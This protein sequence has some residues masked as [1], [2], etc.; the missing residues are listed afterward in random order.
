MIQIWLNEDRYPQK[1]FVRFSSTIYK[2]IE[3]IYTYNQNN[4]ESLR[5]CYKYLEGIQN[6]LSNP[7]I[8]FDYTNRFIQYPNGARF[9]QDFDYN[10][11]YTVKQTMQQ[12]K[13]MYISSK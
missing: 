11:G 10:V 13:H 8:A 7:S 5:Q 2:N 9:I 12:I 4:V 1:L 6:Y 3:E